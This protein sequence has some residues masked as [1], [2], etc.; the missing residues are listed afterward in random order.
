MKTK[1]FVALALLWCRPSASI[2]DQREESFS[3]VVGIR[4]QEK[5]EV[6]TFRKPLKLNNEY[7]IYVEP[8]CIL[9]ALPDFFGS[10]SSLCQALAVVCKSFALDK[11]E[12]YL[13]I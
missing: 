9:F 2:P 7:R 11:L 3:C 4:D 10:P 8:C 6:S 12:F 5:R 13:C 1:P